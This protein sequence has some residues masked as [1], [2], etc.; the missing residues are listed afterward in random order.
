MKELE[1]TRKK[2]EKSKK[3]AAEGAETETAVQTTTGLQ[4]N[5]NGSGPQ[6]QRGAKE[7]GLNR[8]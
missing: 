7:G 1:R 3:Q 2:V 8:D 6:P 4:T 5:R